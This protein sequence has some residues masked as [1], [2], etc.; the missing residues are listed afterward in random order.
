M[1][2]NESTLK[3]TALDVQGNQRFK[4]DIEPCRTKDKKKIRILQN[5]NNDTERKKKK[6][7]FWESKVEDLEAVPIGTCT[8]M[9]FCVMPLGN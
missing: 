1:V 3:Y 9:L 2:I 6:D 4:L 7:I 8:E 5:E